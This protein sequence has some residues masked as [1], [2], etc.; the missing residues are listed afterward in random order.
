MLKILP[1]QSKTEQEAF[2]ARCGVKYRADLLAY[3]A[4]VDDVLVGVCQFTLKDTGGVLYDLAPVPGTQPDKEALFIMGRAALNFIDLCGVHQAVF[5]G[6]PAVTGEQLLH[7][8][9]F[10]PAADGKLHMDLTDF[11]T[12]PCQHHRE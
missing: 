5:D 12:S 3:A 11:F 6:D 7:A 8:I 9:G 2:C 4:T 1:I 10:R